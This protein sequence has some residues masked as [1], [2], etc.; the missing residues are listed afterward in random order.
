MEVQR[1]KLGKETLDEKQEAQAGAV[2]S[3]AT[4]GDVMLSAWKTIG[5]LC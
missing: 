2:H 4:S 5:R 3:E 1:P